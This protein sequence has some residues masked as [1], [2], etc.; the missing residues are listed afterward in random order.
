MTKKDIVTFLM[1]FEDNIPIGVKTDDLL[2][3]YTYEPK[4]VPADND[5]GA[6]ITIYRTGTVVLNTQR[7]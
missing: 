5:F 6:R 2:A 3:P 7:R 4:Y 1:P